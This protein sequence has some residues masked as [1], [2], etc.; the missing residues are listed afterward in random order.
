MA[1][2]RRA[3]GDRDASP[4]GRCSLCRQQRSS[5]DLEAAVADARRWLAARPAP[6]AASARPEMAEGLALLDAELGGE[7]YRGLFADREADVPLAP[8]LADLLRQQVQALARRYELGA[9]AAVPSRDWRQRDEALAIAAAALGVPA[10]PDLLAWADEPAARQGELRNNDQR[11]DNVDGKM[12]LGG[13]ARPR[14]ALLVLDDF[15]G[16]GATLREAGR[17]LRKQ[18]RMSA[19]IV[20]LTLAR[21]RWKLGAAGRVR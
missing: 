7:L 19:P 1:T 9:V 20:P 14:G 4:C 18:G 21:V 12:T 8:E 13:L 11:R 3:L 16:S 10:L 5:V 2:L 15:I 6:I 17:V